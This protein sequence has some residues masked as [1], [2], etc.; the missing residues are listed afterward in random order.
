MVE[1]NKDKPIQSKSI[2]STLL[3]VA[4]KTTLNK[5]GKEVEPVNAMERRKI[6]KHNKNRAKKLKRKLGDKQ[7][8]KPIEKKSPINKLRERCNVKSAQLE[9]TTGN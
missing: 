2:D 5:N 7:P 4:W 8:E 9:E 6:H 1:A 3:K